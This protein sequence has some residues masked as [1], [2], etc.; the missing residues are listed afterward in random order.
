MNENKRSHQRGVDI[1]PEDQ[2][3]RFF[4]PREKRNPSDPIGTGLNIGRASREEKEYRRNKQ[5]EY[6]R[7]LDNQQQQLNLQGK[8]PLPRRQIQQADPYGDPYGG[9]AT[10]ISSSFLII[11]YPA[12]E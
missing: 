5:E 10:A 8:S 4:P 11:I 12:H 1:E 7:Q 9:T 2:R 3:Q 6:K